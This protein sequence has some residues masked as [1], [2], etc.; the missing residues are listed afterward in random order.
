[1][2]EPSKAITLYGETRV[3]QYKQA[4]KIVQELTDDPDINDQ[5][6]LSFVLDSFNSNNSHIDV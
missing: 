3:E 4:K 2:T 6:V 5:D 1:M